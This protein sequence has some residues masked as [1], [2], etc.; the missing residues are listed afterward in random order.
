MDNN[1]TTESA[2]ANRVFVLGRDGEP[3]APCC[4]QRAWKLIKAKRVRKRWYH[5]DLHAIQLK[6]RDRSNAVPAELDVRTT[7]GVKTTGIAVV[8]KTP[9]EDRVVYQEEITHRNDIS[10]RLVERKAHRRRRRGQIWFRPKRFD[11]RARPEGWT[12]PTIKSIVS[13]Q[14]HSVLRLLRLTGATSAT[15]QTGKFDTHKILRPGIKGI[16]YQQGPL[17]KT[18]TR[19]YVAQQWKHRCAYCSAKDWEA[20]RPFNLEH[21]VPRSAGGATNIHNLVWACEPCN[22]RKN[23]TPVED[24]LAHD[25][26]RLNQIVQTTTGNAVPLAR[27]GLYAEICKRLVTRLKATGTQVDETTGADTANA[28]KLFGV[29]KSAAN[30]AACCGATEPVTRL[31][32]PLRLKATGHGRRKQIK[33]RHGAEYMAWRHLPP[34]ERKRTPCPKHA[35]RPNIVNGIRTGDTAE[36]LHEKQ[37]VRGRAQVVASKSRVYVKT[38]AAKRST[39]NPAKMRRIAPR[40]GYQKSN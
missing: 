39:E 31:R 37:W 23:S 7:P 38:T 18:H 11:N 27:T 32:H 14:V 33:G 13:N 34:S 19:A 35:V 22:R 15:V 28:R 8:M 30:D 40:N 25:P 6:D 17:Y 12:R 26:E 5:P 9:T 4:V 3:L 36:I 10:R 24:F 20:S 16:Q 21:V 2:S 29:R 1:P